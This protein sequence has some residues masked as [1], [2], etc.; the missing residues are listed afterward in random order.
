MKLLSLLFAFLPS[1]HAD[2]PSVHGMLVFGNEHVYVSHLPMFHS[3]HDYQMIAEL[4]L[5]PAALA[6]YRAS[7]Y[8]PETVYT[9]VPEKLVLPELVAHPHPFLADLYQGHFERGGTPIAEEITVKLKKVLLF[10]KFVPGQ[11]KPTL[12]NFFLFGTPTEAFLAH[13]ILAKPDF[14]QVIAVAPTPLALDGKVR[15]LTSE[16]GDAPLHAPGI[17]TF[18]SDKRAIPSLNLV[19]EIYFETGDLSH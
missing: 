14:D 15:T 6:K 11:G 3:P 1:A 9:L 10:Q 7:L 17:A 16:A 2:A 18:V 19:K 4:E 13:E 5:P 8:S 12:T